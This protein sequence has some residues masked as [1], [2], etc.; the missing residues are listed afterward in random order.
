MTPK[1]SSWTIEDLIDLE[2]FLHRDQNLPNGQEKTEQNKLDRSFYL[3][4]IEP[5]ISESHVPDNVVIRHWLEFRRKSE[6]RRPPLDHPTLPGD[7][8]KQI[9]AFMTLMFIILGFCSGS[10]LSFSFL[11]YKGSAPLNIS[12]YLGLFVL[13]QVFLIFLVLLYLIFARF[14]FKINNFS[15]IRMGVY[16]ILVKLSMWIKKRSERHF[17]VEKRSEFK[18]ALGVI[19]G[20]SRH[21]SHLFPWPVFILTQVFAIFFNIGVLIATLLRVIGSDLAFGWQ[22]TLQLSAAAVHKATVFLSYPW[23]W[24]VPDYLAHPS[25]SQ[26][27]GSRIILKDG[28]ARLGTPD[29]IAW[30]PFLCFAVLFYGLIP[31]LV[32]L[33][34]AHIMKQRALKRINFQSIAFD[35]LLIRLRSPSLDTHGQPEHT[36]MHHS[37]D[38]NPQAPVSMSP[39][40]GPIIVLVPE[41]IIESCHDLEL[42]KHIEALFRSPFHQKAAVSL[43]MD[44]DEK[45]IDALFP[46]AN[47]RMVLLMEAWQ[48]PI[49][50]IIHYIRALKQRGG[51]NFRLHLLLAGKPED[52]TIFTKP[53]D[54]D[55]R[56]WKQAINAL[57]DPN[58]SIESL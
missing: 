14:T 13:T 25:L 21:Y 3:E 26:I 12:S 45:I 48:P 22:S 7:V 18:A 55:L 29:L 51:Q 43:R 46:Q 32:F 31:R 8:F 19:Q 5:M 2:Y 49:R 39:H 52:Q 35:R 1:T 44:H 53:E 56:V 54:D 4:S 33:T 15:L 6:K 50:E 47:C 23:A 37:Y 28:I 42:K 16:S 57:A 20:K 34:G 11:I 41:D 38:L 17:S 40:G 9:Y 24:F 58:I 30:W 27:E 10:G 36:P